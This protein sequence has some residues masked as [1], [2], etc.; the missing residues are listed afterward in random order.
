MRVQIGG[1][2]MDNDSARI[3]RRY[4]YNDVCCP[5]DVRDALAV[6]E[7]EE[8]LIFEVNSGGGSAYRGLE[9]Y[10][11]LRESKRHVT[12]E[13]Q[14]I[15]ASAA[16]VFACGADK[17]K[18]SPVANVMVHRAATSASGTEQDM[19]EA[20]QMLR[21]VDESILNAYE[22][23]CKKKT[24]RDELK[25]L[26]KQQTFFT[27]QE[28]L[29]RGLAD[30]IMWQD[31]DP[32]S[33]L[34]SS[35]VAMAG[36]IRQAFACLPPI[37]ELERCQQEGEGAP[38]HT[39][40]VENTTGKPENKKEGQKMPMTME[41]LERDNQ[42]LLAEIRTNAAK[43]ERERLAGIDAMS[44]A[45]YEDLIEAAKKDPAATAESVAV[46]IVA[47][48]KKQGENFLNGRAAD[49]QDGNLNDVGTATPAGG[50]NSEEEL[51]AIL[52]E[53]FKE[54]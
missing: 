47:R 54:T 16:S 17:V 38:V 33:R 2:V 15:A 35:A 6:P 49:V 51:N 28:A 12:V 20:G 39:D 11:L 3:Y 5:Q 21:T 53:V 1:T 31:Q 52:D 44:M 42:A 23:K 18:I 48:Q 45:G 46:Q 4:G 50:E 25:E 30:E 36:G 27:A 37:S 40:S 8:G 26:M 14:S 9:M 34:T 10:T 22:D 32:E 41:E 7:D 29:D 24:T 13:I 43:A 19:T